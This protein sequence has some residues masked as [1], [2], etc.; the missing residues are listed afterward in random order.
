MSGKPD[1]P[2]SHSTHASGSFESLAELVNFS[3]E[4]FE[5]NPLVLEER[6]YEAQ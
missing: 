5:F 2:R 3:E 6:S 1:I 4:S